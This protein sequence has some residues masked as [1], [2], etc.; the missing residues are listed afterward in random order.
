[1]K[2]YDMYK[3]VVAV[4]C[5]ITGIEEKPMLHSNKEA[6]VDARSILIN[7]LTR[8]GFTEC[9]ISTLTGLSQ[10]CVNKL[11]NNFQSR[12]TKWSVRT[13]LQSINNELTT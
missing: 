3:N 8:M 6:C 2:I 13:N 12:L 1:M 9:E 11:K 4:V 10:Q 5:E 7:T